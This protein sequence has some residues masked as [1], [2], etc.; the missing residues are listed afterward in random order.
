MSKIAHE[1]GMIAAGK[2]L[3]AKEFEVDYKKS[4]K[5]SWFSVS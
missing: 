4:P 1:A 5:K 2:K 3:P